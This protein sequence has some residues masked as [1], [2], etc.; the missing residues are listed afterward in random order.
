M[1][2]QTLGTQQTL[3]GQQPAAAPGPGTVS[4]QVPSTVR[5]GAGPVNPP[6]T[7]A[8]ADEH[9]RWPLLCVPEH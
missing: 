2:P 8:G 1:P 3:G 7:Q 6:Q 9:G 5:P 4:S